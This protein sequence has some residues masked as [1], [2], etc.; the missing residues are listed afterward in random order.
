MLRYILRNVVLP[1]SNLAGR[2]TA[3][4]GVPRSKGCALCVKRRV[5]CDQNL[6]CKALYNTFRAVTRAFYLTIFA[7]LW[8][9]HQVWCRVPRV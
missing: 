5:K 3:M 8:K 1:V 2:T 9:L 4:V 6:P 7:S